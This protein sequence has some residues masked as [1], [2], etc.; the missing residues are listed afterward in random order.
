VRKF[1]TAILFVLLLTPLYA[2]HRPSSLSIKILNDNLTLGLSENRDDLRSYGISFQYNQNQKWFL[3]LEASG[4]T[5]RIEPTGRYDEIVFNGGYNFDFF[6]T[7]GKLP[8]TIRLTPS[9]G[10]LVAGNLGFQDVQNKVHDTFN[11]GDLILHYETEITKF[12]PQIAFKNSYNTFVRAPFSGESFLMAEGE[13]DVTYTINYQTKINTSFALGQRTVHKSEILIG[14]GYE[15]TFSETGWPSHEST[16][17]SESG[18][19]TFVKA[20]FGFLALS[21]KWYLETLQGYGGLGFDIGLSQHSEWTH[22]DIIFSMGIIMPHN[23]LTSFLR[24]NIKHNI[25]FYMSNAFKMVP[26]ESSSWARE[27]YSVWQMGA[28]WEIEQLEY[29][30]LRPFVSMGLGLDHFLV[31]KDGANNQRMSVIDDVRFVINPAL[32]IRLFSKGELSYD[33]V[34]YGFEFSGGV[35]GAFGKIRDSGYDLSFTE[36]WH[37][38][39]KI[40]L[41]MSSNL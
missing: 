10:F 22:N 40:A 41:I 25:G 27:N 7:K 13:V 29:K 12:Y 6:F 33:G 19:T 14:M 3:N 35:R 16:V 31:A 5:K 17:E 2:H 28:D 11:L 15:W 23:M 8:L 21:Y 1:V 20:H 32:G 36:M 38:Y 37:P 9:A 30:V 39:G 34:A 24:Y 18:L 4:I 26:L